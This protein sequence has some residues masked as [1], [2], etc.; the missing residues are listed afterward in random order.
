MR[1][2]PVS[3]RAAPLGHRSPSPLL[4]AA[5]LATLAAPA[6][7]QLPGGWERAVERM[8]TLLNRP[9]SNPAWRA[10]TLAA[11]TLPRF[12][13]EVGRTPANRAAWARFL[14]LW[15]VAL[16]RSEDAA[17][18]R[19]RAAEALAFDYETAAGV[20]AGYPEKAS[21]LVPFPPMDPSAV[22]T[23][24]AQAPPDSTP[25]EPEK[26]VPVSSP[27]TS[28]KGEAAGV[29]K[30]LAL[31]DEVGLVARPLLVESSGHLGFDL[32]VM[33][34]LREWVFRPASRSGKAA[35]GA[36]LLSVTLRSGL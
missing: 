36:Y 21:L 32:A 34:S 23:E 5:L 15:A 8:E 19:W 27:F 24:L 6:V 12:A 9:G 11:E 33:D 29:A 13:D 35:P 10:Q 14:A 7:G 1:S 28:R 30:V 16:L 20:L 26:L 22:L 25:P 18:A 31:V 17:W 3:R 2:R 4:A